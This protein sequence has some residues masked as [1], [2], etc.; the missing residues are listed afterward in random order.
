MVE[1]KKA[2]MDVEAAR[3]VIEVRTKKLCAEAVLPKRQHPTDAGCDLVA[4]SKRYDEMGN[5]VYG[6][7]IAM[8]IPEGYVGL[9]FPRSSIANY[10]LTLSNGVGVID[11]NYRGEITLNF[12]PMCIQATWWSKLMARIC[13]RHIKA[14]ADHSVE[15][16]VGE[17]IG[18]III[19]PY[20]NVEFYE[21]PF[22]SE[23]DRGT[24]GYGSTGK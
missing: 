16:K 10:H 1:V 6:T 12:R 9:I 11:S 5:T 13:R 2:A 19:L 4:V 23:T 22:L 8:E 7:G 17:R 24:G 3:K 15:Y 21:W 20:P 14:V 18:Q